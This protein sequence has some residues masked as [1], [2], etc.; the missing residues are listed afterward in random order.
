MGSQYNL[1]LFSN[2]LPYRL[3]NSLP[4][5][6]QT[7]RIMRFV[8]ASVNLRR[9]SRSWRQ[10]PSWRSRNGHPIARGQRAQR[11]LLP[12][13]PFLTDAL[14]FRSPRA[15]RSATFLRCHITARATGTASDDRLV[16]FREPMPCH[17]LYFKSANLESAAPGCK[18]GYLQTLP[19]AAQVCSSPSA[20]RVRPS[21]RLGGSPES[22]ADQPYHPLI[23]VRSTV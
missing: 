22:T 11:T 20:H 9:T 3:P 14:P 12:A 16:A 23:C 17:N 1:S 2:R 15:G 4:T 7:R 8:P 5:L 6:Q 10:P 18:N 13:I 21:M 19:P